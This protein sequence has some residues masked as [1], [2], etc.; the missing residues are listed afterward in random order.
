MPIQPWREWRVAVV[1]FGSI[2]RRHFE[3]LGRL[4]VAR[5]VLVRRAQ[6]ANAAFASPADADVVHSAAEALA[7]GLNLVIV[8]NP[9]RWHVEAALEY[10]A[11]RVPVLVEKPLSHSLAEAERLMEWTRARR[12]WAG[13]AYCMRYHP[14]YRLAREALLAGRVGRPLYAKAWFETYLP[15]WHPW[16]DYRTSYAARPEL[17][18]GVLPTLDHELDFLNWC[19][20]PPKTACGWS[21][22]T[23]AL[24]MTVPDLAALSIEYGG[25]VRATAHFSLCRRDAS[26]GFEF[27]GS[28]GTLRYR[29]DQPRLE[30]ALGEQKTD[31]LWDGTEFDLN[32]MYVEMLRDALQA[33]A[34]G[35]EPP[36][37]LAAGLDA[38][39]LA[40]AIRIT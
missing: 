28:Q 16:E 26:R 1:G 17:G 14:A 5:R 3:N 25:G 8:C 37:P 33:L 21:T 36:I 18:G 32:S 38:L 24:D 31:V 7:A 23:S 27:V 6:G 19:F 13:M 2:G 35:R 34:A 4:G 30:L 20:G 9:T 15:D 29:F 39:R 11:A 22:I 12:L 40:A 10:I